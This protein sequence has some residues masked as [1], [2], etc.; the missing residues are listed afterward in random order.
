M[1]ITIFRLLNLCDLVLNIAMH[2]STKSYTALK[3]M[4]AFEVI[5]FRVFGCSPQ[6]F[7]ITAFSEENF[8]LYLNGFYCFFGRIDNIYCV[9]IKCFGLLFSLL[10]LKFSKLKYG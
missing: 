2:F 4:A 3:A 5:V 10:V 8:P 6:R 9:H 1:W 7:L